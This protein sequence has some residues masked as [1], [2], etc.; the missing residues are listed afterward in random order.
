MV[1]SIAL[2]ACAGSS[3]NYNPHPDGVDYGENFRGQYHF[4]P[5]SEW[6]NDVN[7]LTSMNCLSTETRAR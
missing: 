5:K 3:Q 1:F 2:Q 4:S 6:M 7:A